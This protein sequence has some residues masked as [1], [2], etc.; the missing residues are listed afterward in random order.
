M[1]RRYQCIINVYSSLYTTHVNKLFFH[2]ISTPMMDLLIQITTAHKIS[3]AGHLIHV[4]SDSR[5]LTYKPST[6]IGKT[7]GCVQIIIYS[8]LF[9]SS[10]FVSLSQ[11]HS[12]LYHFETNLLRDLHCTIRHR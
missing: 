7:F 3:P 2:A 8:L 9:L 6:P 1:R 10:S 11:I 5:L 12:L 4:V